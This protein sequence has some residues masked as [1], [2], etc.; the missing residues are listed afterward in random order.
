MA[1]YLIKAP[2]LVGNQFFPADTTNPQEI[3]LDDS[4]DPSRTW[5]PLDKGAK[6]A[7][8][9][10]GVKKAVV[11]APVAADPDPAAD[12]L[13]GAQEV[14]KEPEQIEVEA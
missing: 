2:A 5:T 8:A 4:V 1:R 3:T 12:T 14:S 7:L 9:R 13:A 11:A 10:L 6:A